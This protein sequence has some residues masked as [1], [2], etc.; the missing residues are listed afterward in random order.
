MKCG[1]VWSKSLFEHVRHNDKACQEMCDK[2]LAVYQDELLPAE[3]FAEL[4]DVM[5]LYIFINICIDVT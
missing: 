1:E 3:S 2:I 4:I 5:G